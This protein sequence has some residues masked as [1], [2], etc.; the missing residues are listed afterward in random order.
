MRGI[1]RANAKL[2]WNEPWPKVLEPNEAYAG[3]G[4]STDQLRLKWR[5]QYSTNGL[6]IGSIIRQ[7]SPL[8]NALY[9][10]NS[11]CSALNPFTASRH[12][13]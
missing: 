12:A 7:D 10:R 5:G 1:L 2:R 4:K 9:H 8:D 11:H 3:N 6:W 13:L